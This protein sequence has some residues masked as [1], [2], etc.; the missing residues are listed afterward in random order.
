M[1]THAP[2]HTGEVL[3]EDAVSADIQPAK[4]P[5]PYVNVLVQCLTTSRKTP[6]QRARIRASRLK[7]LPDVFV[8]E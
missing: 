1:K 7:H 3:R 4:S 6:E 5:K 8:V 2:I